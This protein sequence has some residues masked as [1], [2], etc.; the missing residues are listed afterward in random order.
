MSISKKKINNCEVKIPEL[1]GL[2]QAKKWRGSNIFNCR[3]FV[4][5]NV[6]RRNRGKTTLV[7]TIVQN[8]TTKNMIVFFYCPTFEKDASYKPIIEYLDSKG[9]IYHHYGNVVEDGVNNIELFIQQNTQPKEEEPIEEVVEEKPT[10]CLFDKQV[11][12]KV[13]PSE[14]KEKKKK[15]E[16]PIEYLFVFDDIPD[17]LKNPMVVK[18]CKLSRHLLAKIVIS[19][20]SIIDIDRAIYQNCDYVALYNGFNE[21]NLKKFHFRAEPGLPYEEFVELYHEVTDTENVR[22][23]TATKRI[24]NF[25]LIDRKADV[26]RVNLNYVI[27]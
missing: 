20:Q 7:N 6:G 23:S 26:F 13:P 2:E 1:N 9:I 14:P 3:Y 15:K 25:L 19:T 22:Y 27:E 8:F 24:Y 5:A 16:K 21:D 18:L 12:I 17:G 11:K 4:L 10:P